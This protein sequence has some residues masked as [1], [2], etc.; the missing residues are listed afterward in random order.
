MKRRHISFASSFYPSVKP[1]IFLLFFLFTIGSSIAQQTTLKDIFPLAVGNRWTYNYSSDSYGIYVHAGSS[2][3]GT[4][5]Y[6]ITGKYVTNDST[7]WNV[8]QR[9]EYTVVVYQGPT[10]YQKDSTTF[11]LVEKNTGYHEIYST[12]SDASC[13]FPFKKS[14]ADTSK[15]YRYKEVSSTSNISV[16]LTTLDIQ[17]PYDIFKNKYKFTLSCDSGIVKMSYNYLSY[18]ASKT[19]NYSLVN[20]ITE[21]EVQQPVTT[22]LPGDYTILYQNYPNPFN[23]STNISYYIPRQSFVEIRV[24]DLLGRE[25][26]LLVNDEKPAGKHLIQFNCGNLTSGVYFYSIKAGSFFD[27]KKFILIK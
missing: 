12:S 7:I 22:G 17:S 24:Y 25:I 15:F 16:N 27:I 3:S 14:S 21:I 20:R 26:G 5:F 10:L 23:P 9:K 4:A 13:I 18:S 6:K 2:Q 8:F 1:V 19:A 11:N